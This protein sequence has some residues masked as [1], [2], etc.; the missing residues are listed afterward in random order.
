MVRR[1]VRAGVN[2]RRQIV[3]VVVTVSRSVSCVD[4]RRHGVVPVGVLGEIVRVD[5]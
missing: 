5:A 2:G 1:A 3:A 4:W